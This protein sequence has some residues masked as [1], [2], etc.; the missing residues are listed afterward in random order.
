MSRF[1][2]PFLH[3]LSPYVPG[4]QPRRPMVKLNTN[5]NPY[6]PSPRAIAAIRACADGLRLYPDPEAAAL[7]GAVGRTLGLG[8]DHVFVGN[9]SDEVLGHAFNA[10]FRH[11]GP[12]VFPDITYAFYDSYCRLYGLPVRRVPLRADLTLDPAALDGPSAGLVIANPNAPTGLALPLDRV[13]GILRAHP[14]RVVIVDE[15]YVDFGA[16]SAA[17]LVA[18]HD[19]LLVVQ[20]FSKSR[21]LAGLRVGFAVG[22]PHLMDGLRRVKDSFNSYPLGIPAQAGALAAWEDRD[23][24]EE[25]RRRV[26]A[27]RDQLAAALRQRGFD[28]PPSQANFLFAA[29]PTWTG[30]H[31]ASGLRA[32]GVLVRHFPAPRI[33]DRLRISIGTAEDCARLLSAL[34]AVMAAPGLTSSGSACRPG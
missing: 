27:D 11:G 2:S 5:E 7:R 10:F 17:T 24:F 4:E 31:L 26:I 21:S 1:W 30:A 12:V 23:W 20:T 29:N 32:E 16:D 3:D 8:A 34:D 19:N 22:Q 6:G 9:G 28:V 18:E 13:R 14:D 33:K 15:A 25:T